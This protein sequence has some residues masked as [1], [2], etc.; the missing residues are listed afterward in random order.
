MFEDTFASVIEQD[1]AIAYLKL[2]G[3]LYYKQITVTMLVETAGYGRATFY[4]YF[5]GLRDLRHKLSDYD[6]E[7]TRQIYSKALEMSDSEKRKA[8]L[9]KELIPHV[10]MFW[11]LMHENN[12][13]NHM[14]NMKKCLYELFKDSFTEKF[15][16][17]KFDP[18]IA[19][20]F[21]VAGMLH[22]MLRHFSNGDD[23]K[24]PE[25]I[26]KMIEFINHILF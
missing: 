4:A 12:M 2:L 8:Y 20:N 11:P 21:C 23:V 14:D 1:F 26:E 17:T 3:Q 13:P 7:I 5:S 24:S 19:E 10:K 6:I 16:N 22:M 18:A 25:I 9:I 15:Q